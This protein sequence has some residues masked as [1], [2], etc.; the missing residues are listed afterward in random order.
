M[1][2][3]GNDTEVPGVFHDANL[4]FRSNTRNLSLNTCHPFFTTHFS[5]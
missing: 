2:D 3:M 4:L 5:P 1:V